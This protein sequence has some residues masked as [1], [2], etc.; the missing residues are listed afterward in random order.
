MI[1][2]IRYAWSVPTETAL[3]TLARYAPIIELGA[4]TGHWAALLRMRG[5]DVLAYD[6]RCWSDAFADA[7]ASGGTAGGQA[8]GASTGSAAPGG[9]ATGTSLIE[10][11]RD[12]C[13]AEGGPEAAA[14]HAGRA[15]LLAWPDYR[16]LG[17]YASC[18]LAHYTGS[19]L[20]LL[21]EWRGRTL[22]VHAPPGKGEHGQSFSAAFQM[23]VE[24]E[25]RLVEQE[26]L[27]SWPFFIDSLMVWTRRV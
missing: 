18:C 21:G 17:T 12:L 19:T 20:L 4:G 16:G 11:D 5:V 25:W 9:V 6:T 8:G 26:R 24:A 27:P 15:L 3:A 2:F 14:A 7:D 10:G 13:V 22:G 1:A 23:K